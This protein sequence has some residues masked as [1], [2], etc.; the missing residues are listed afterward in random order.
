MEQD[1]ESDILT[2]SEESVFSGLEDSGSDSITEEEDDH[3]SRVE[4][5]S[6]GIL[7]SENMQVS[8]VP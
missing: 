4:R 8:I 2:D 7:C 1:G 3:D 5:K 6:E